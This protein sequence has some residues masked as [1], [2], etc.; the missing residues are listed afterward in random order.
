MIFHH[1][2]VQH[3]HFRPLYR[4]TLS[5]PPPTTKRVYVC[6]CA[7]ARYRNCNNEVFQSRSGLLRSRKKNAWREWELR[8]PSLRTDCVSN[9]NHMRYRLCRSAVWKISLTRVT[10]LKCRQKSAIIWEFLIFL[11]FNISYIFIPLHEI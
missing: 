10:S 7:R 2:L 11:Y 3:T 5:Q 8:I 1:G 4:G 9:A 6:V